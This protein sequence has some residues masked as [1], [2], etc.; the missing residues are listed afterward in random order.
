MRPQLQIRCWTTTRYPAV[1]WIKIRA[2]QWLQIRSNKSGRCLLETSYSVALVPIESPHVSLN[3]LNFSWDFHA[4]VSY[5][6]QSDI[7]EPHGLGE[8]N[9]QRLSG[10]GGVK[11][12]TKLLLTH[13]SLTTVDSLVL[14]KPIWLCTELHGGAKTAPLYFCN[15]FVKTFCSEIIIGRYI[16]Q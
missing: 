9:E 1:D 10:F 14:E 6:N 15:N 16:L 5:K 12:M 13:T 11:R 4:K 3:K 2:V 8:R 7:V